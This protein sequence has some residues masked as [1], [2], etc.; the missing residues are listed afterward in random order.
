MPSQRNLERLRGQASLETVRRGTGS[1][2][3][4]V[5]LQTSEGERWILVRLGSNPFDDP[6]AQKL[7]GHTIEVE[8][9]RVGREFRY[10]AVREIS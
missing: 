9:Y 1:E 2:H 8:G 7:S 10:S 4:G 3:V 6:E 5:V